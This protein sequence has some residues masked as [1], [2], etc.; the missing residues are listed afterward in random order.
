MS[1]VGAAI[2]L[3]ES[4]LAARS[5]A[6]LGHPAGL[7]AAAARGAAA[8][9]RPQRRGGDRRRRPRAWRGADIALVPELANAQ[10]YEVPAAFFQR[11]LGPR[12]KYS[13]AWWGDGV[14]TLAAAEVAALD[15]TIAHA[16]IADGMR[17]LDLGCGWGSLRAGARRPLPALRASSASRTRAASAPSSKR[18]RGGAA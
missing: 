6:A 4:R 10:H 2:D 12:L 7:R 17:I 3:A 9:R 5:G 1:A 18:R 8:P 11:V 13:C 15:L 16:G 14:A